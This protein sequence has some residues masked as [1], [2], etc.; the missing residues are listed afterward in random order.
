MWTRRELMTGSVMGGMAPAFEAGA[1]TLDREALK[2]VVAELRDIKSELST[3][4]DGAALPAAIV[5][6][7][8]EQL[9]MF[10]RASG[11]F[12]DF[13][14]VGS[15]VFYQLYDWH[16]KNA[17]PLVVGRQPDGR[18]ALQF[19]FTRLI[20]RPESDANHVG[21]PYDNR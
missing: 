1:Q 16:V 14:D 10:L 18:Y 7:I 8:R 17:H 15:S 5:S 20:L 6:K 11:K 13:V 19:M 3:L 2:D 21:P 4:A 12:P 9:S